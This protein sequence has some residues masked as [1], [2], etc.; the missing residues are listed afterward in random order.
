VYAASG[1]YAVKLTVANAFGSSSASQFV[2]TGGPPQAEF[3][4]Q[5]SGLQAIFADLSTGSPSSWRWDF[6]DG[7]TDT[8]QSPTHTYAAAGTYNVT[9]QA[10]NAA[11]STQ[12]SHFVS[13]S[14]G[15]P[16]KAKFSVQVSGLQVIFTDESTGSPSAWD[17]AF[18]DGSAHATTQNAS[19]TYAAAGTYRATLSVSNAGG[20]SS[21]SQFVTVTAPPD[22]EFTYNILAANTLA[23]NFIDESTGSPTAWLW[24]FG[25][26]ALVPECTSTEQNPSHVYSTAGTYTVLLTAKNAAGQSTQTT[27]ITAGQPTA[28][29]TF[30]VSGLSVTFTDASLGSPTQY[31]WNFGDCG[32]SPSTCLSNVAS[33]MH[34]YAAPGS[35]VVRLTVTNAAGSDAVAHLVTVP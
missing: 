33:P 30:S 15:D 13:V 23:V 8:A 28:E 24:N 29:F 7:A 6:G 4:W 11:G 26:C 5:T 2:T 21:A 10:T 3:S 20:S 34:T 27:S 32:A 17:W 16:P 12:K 14:P 35:Y 25:D 9:L 31:A 19:R 22:A 1:T 18:G